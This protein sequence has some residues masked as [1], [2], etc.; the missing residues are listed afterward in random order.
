LLRHFSRQVTVT[1]SLIFVLGCMSPDGSF[2]D[3]E[4]NVLTATPEEVR[5]AQETL[6]SIQVESDMLASMKGGVLFDGDVEALSTGRDSSATATLRVVH[7][8]S[9]P[10]GDGDLVSVQTPSPE[11]GGVRFVEGRRFRVFA[12][13]L[14]GE[15]RTWSSAGTVERSAR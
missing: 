14:D 4:G 11:K 3:L 7:R 12:V 15:L 9:G 8:I 6:L 2:H 5:K 13:E 10:F 1:L